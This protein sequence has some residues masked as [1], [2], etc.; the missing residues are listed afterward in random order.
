MEKKP[1]TD[2]VM[3]ILNVFIFLSMIAAAVLLYT[4][5]K[6]QEAFNIMFTLAL[7]YCLIRLTKIEKYMWGNK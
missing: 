2:R 6:T 3:N 7:Y 1:I 4:G 5:G